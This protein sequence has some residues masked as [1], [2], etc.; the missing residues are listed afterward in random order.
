MTSHFPAVSTD[1]ISTEDPDLVVIYDL[2]VL[3]DEQAAFANDIL[4]KIGYVI[5]AVSAPL[6]IC[7]MAVFLHP[8]MRSATS[9]FVVGLNIAQLF[10]LVS[11]AGLYLLQ[12]TL[13][14]WANSLVYWAYYFYVGVYIAVVARRGSYVIMSL[15]STERLYAILRPLHVQEFCLSK[16]PITSMLLA[17]LAASL[18]HLYLLVRTVVVG[19]EDGSSGRVVYKLKR[20]D[21][22]YSNKDVNDGFNLL[23]KVVLVYV[24]LFLQIVLN[25]LTAWALRHHNM[26]TKHVQTSANNEAKRQRERQM[27]IT[28]LVTTVCYVILSLPNAVH[29]MVHAVMDEYNPFSKYHNLFFVVGTAAYNLTLL[30]CG[31]DFVCF[32]A[33]SSRYKLTLLRLLGLREKRARG[34]VNAENTQTE[35][36]MAE[37]RLESAEKSN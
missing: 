5:I 13:N 4:T 17:Y 8:R 18:L 35:L 23:A 3:T 34:D 7:N 20:T 12:G 14:A 29:S 28:I 10:Y 27:T 30:S 37:S 31:I 25:V 32:V 11:A 9:K 15:V 26:S 36:V 19:V 22:Y 21:F 2:F 6:T 33:L 1:E 16:Y 24:A